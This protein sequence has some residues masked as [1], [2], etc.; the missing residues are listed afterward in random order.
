MRINNV[1]RVGG[2]FGRSFAF[3][4]RLKESEKKGYTSTI[5]QAMDYLGIVNRALIIHGSSFPSK[6]FEQKIGSP[7]NNENFLDF[8]KL[9]GF[10]GVQLGPTGKLNRGDSSP[11]SSSIFAKNPLFIDLSQL[12]DEEYASILPND[13]LVDVVNSTKPDDKNWTLTD[14]KEAEDINNAAMQTAYDNFAQMLDEGDKTAEK[15]WD[16]FEDF[17]ND[18]AYWLEDYAVLD[19]ISQKYNTDYYPNWDEKDRTL[20]SEKKKGNK[21]AINE[22]YRIQEENDY[23]IDL[24]KFKQFVID[25]QTKADDK[26][27]GNFVYISDLLV[28][29]S[30]FDELIFE[31]AF[32]KK[33]IHG[34]HYKIG[35]EEGGQYF[36]SPQLWNISLVDP[37][38]LFNRDGS[39]GTSG[40]FIKLKLQ[41]AIQDAKNIRIDHAMGL[42]DPYIY[43]ANSVV[44]KKTRDKNGKII[45]YPDRNKLDAKYLSQSHIDRHHYY[46][47]II[48]EI[49]IPTLKQAGINPKDVVW[50]D[51]GTD[52]TGVFNKIFRE[53]CNLPGIT[54]MLW[55]RGEW[56][57]KD[58]WSYI[59]CHDNA[60]I[61]QTI[62]SGYPKTSDAWNLDYLAG[63]LNP[64]PHRARERENVRREI[65]VSPKALAKAK[66]ADL[67][68]A[69]KNIQIMFT[70]FFGINKRYNTP[71]TT[72]S[73]NWTLRLS[74][75]YEDKY[76]KSLENDDW[77]INM[78]EILSIAVQAKEDMDY[79]QGKAGEKAADGL[80]KKLNHYAKILKE[81]E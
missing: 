15:L 60:T 53:D 22:Y 76:Y 13:E 24:Y 37:D 67:M 62:D 78:P 4:R 31:D 20:L 9:H 71:G 44:Y 80:I 65:E 69:T 47:R 46:K 59:G 79:V 66:L 72:G 48:P 73:D 36:N 54:G 77:A 3:Q 45:S 5:N 38:K 58:N 16:E 14:F 10:N 18:N 33:D 70:D 17:K 61:R 52:K 8:L 11:Y 1:V 6:D 21:E 81:K 64:N 27:R 35:A 39:L 56:A 55:S 43:D 49:V 51:L 74:P 12:G 7:Y 40:K 41:K 28:G 68:R 2:N 63:F 32:L 57:N 75:D 26:K 19:T 50:E 34:R 25:K 29:A 30:S 42:V 23:Q